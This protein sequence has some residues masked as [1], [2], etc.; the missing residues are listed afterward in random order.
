[1][2]SGAEAAGVDRSD[3]PCLAA[4]ANVALMLN[5]PCRLT[6]AEYGALCKHLL[7]LEGSRDKQWEAARNLAMF[8][9]MWSALARSDST[10]SMRLADMCKPIH[11]PNIGGTSRPAVY[12]HGGRQGRDDCVGVRGRAPLNGAGSGIQDCDGGTLAFALDV[13]S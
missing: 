11:L 9:H 6:E 4:L 8:T 1:M 13:P 7:G 3:L 10:L 5:P 2:S 12:L